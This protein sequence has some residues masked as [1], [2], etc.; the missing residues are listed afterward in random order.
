MKTGIC[1]SKTTNDHI[2]TRAKSMSI[3]TTVLV[4]LVKVH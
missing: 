1:E 4:F 3:G 2:I